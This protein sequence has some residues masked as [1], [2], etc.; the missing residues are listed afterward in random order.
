LQCHGSTADGVFLCA[1]DTEQFLTDLRGVP[2]L[3]E[4]LDTL[5]TVMKA[6]AR[7]GISGGGLPGS[8]APGD[9]EA[10]NSKMT[11]ENLLHGLYWHAGNTIVVGLEAGTYVA[12]I[13]AG[14]SG[15]I[16][17]KSVLSYVTQLR[18]EVKHAERVL[19]GASYSVILGPCETV[20][21]GTTLK[22]N[23]GAT[24]ATCPT[25]TQ[26]YIIGG[27]LERRAMEALGHDG[28]PLRAAQAVTYLNGQGMNLTTNHIKNWVRRGLAHRD[29]DPQGRKLFSIVD[30]YK[31]AKRETA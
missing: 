13:V 15:V 4:E 22:A 2:D 16:G 3:I 9:F 30:I 6:P 26:T 27:F 11:L 20:S 1:T 18:Y 31:Y 28:T 10:L 25:C 17:H 23:E 14:L 24:E 8:K 7:G 19:E 21:C 5:M 12:E 29:T